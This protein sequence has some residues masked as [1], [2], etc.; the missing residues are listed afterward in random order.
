MVDETAKIRELQQRIALY[1]DMKAYGELFELL[2]SGL[3]RFSYA[4]VRSNE[5][6]EEIVSDVFVKLWQIRNKLP[7]IGNLKVYLYTIAKNFSHNYI[8]KHYKNRTLSLDDAELDTAIAIGDPEEI[9]ISADALNK[10]RE[11]IGQLP[12]QCRLIFQLVK[13]EGL[14]YKEVAA[15]LHVSA[16]TV[17]NQVAIATKKIAGL[18]PTY[19]LRGPGSPSRR[20][21]DS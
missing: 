13:E 8:T 14:Q 16:F 3:H 4:F 19:L 12:P 11:A 20:F 9:C 17:R 6:A 2:F 7:E 18:L 1:E 5:A 21:S 10:V 15:I